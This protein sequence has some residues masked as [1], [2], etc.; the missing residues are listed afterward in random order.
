M[1]NPMPPMDVKYGQ[2]IERLQ[3]N[4]FSL[5][6]KKEFIARLSE[7]VSMLDASRSDLVAAVL[8]IDWASE[9]LSPVF[10][11][12]IEN[13]VSAHAT[14]SLLVAKML[15]GH[16]KYSFS[17]DDK[18]HLALQ[19][20]LTLVPTGPSF[21]VPIL[22]SNLPHKSE[23]VESHVR[24]TKSLLRIMEYCPALEQ[25]ILSIIVESM[26]DVH[27]ALEDLNED[28]I[29]EIHES[30]F[31]MDDIPDSDSD[32][33]DSENG[34]VVQANFRE[35]IAKLDSLM[36]IM[37]QHIQTFASDQKL[38]DANNLFLC[39]LEVFEK[40]VL[41][42]HKIKCVQFLIFLMTTTQ[43]SFPDEFMGFLVTLLLSENTSNVTRVAAACYLGSFIAR[44]KHVSLQ[45][46]K[47]CLNILNRYVQGFV[48]K[49]EHLINGKIMDPER[50][51]VFYAAIQ[52]MLYIFCFHWKKLMLQNDVPQSGAFPVELKEF[53]RVLMSKFQPLT[54]LSSAIV[55]EF[56]KITHDLHIMYC[57]PLV[58]NFKPLAG[59]NSLLERLDT[60][61]PFDPLTLPRSGKFIGQFYNEWDGESEP[62]ET[63]DIES[64]KT[65][66]LEETVAMSTSIG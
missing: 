63:T 41:P 66:S 12:F 8:Q 33:S 49:N 28:E 52:A 44:A 27:L 54:V 26:S 17:I 29:E 14:H 50:Y 5:D 23:D 2:F 47:K 40:F 46:V 11:R 35:L 6:E 43:Q 57:Y 4:Q 3:Q 42:T 64:F 56:S 61:F 15:V 16:K 39:L 19:S 34:L 36:T 30:V 18:L 7:H 59:Q 55:Q 51:C 58:G 1:P 20:L 25:E 31:S 32:D 60:F 48:D 24:Y 10:V 9:A 21:L 53:N 37:M 62:E 13:L 22:A 38:D 45:S 65:L